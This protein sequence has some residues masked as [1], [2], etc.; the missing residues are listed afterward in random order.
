MET[1]ELDK[2]VKSIYNDKSEEK[3]ILDGIINEKVYSK[4]NPKILWILWE[5][6]DDGGWKDY[7]RDSRKW[8]NKTP[9]CFKH[10][11]WQNITYISYGILNRNKQPIE[12]FPESA[13]ILRSIA[14]INISKYPGEHTSPNRW[15]FLTETY[16]K[17]QIALHRQIEYCNPDIIIGSNVIYLFLEYFGLPKKGSSIIDNMSY[18][19]KNSKLFI[20]SPHPSRI[21]K[22]HSNGVIETAIKWLRKNKK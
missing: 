12:K 9:E 13:N 19:E 8:I 4:S 18:W 10:K 5:P 20:F 17:C 6:Y 22:I 16:E 1:K 7:N 2:L 11:T 14:Y 21:S 3:P 15:K